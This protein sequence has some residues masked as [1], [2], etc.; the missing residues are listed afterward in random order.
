M[1]YL[2]SSIA[3]WLKSDPHEQAKRM[4]RLR[5]FGKRLRRDDDRLF[6]QHTRQ[7]DPC[8]RDYDRQ[9]II[10][11]SLVGLDTNEPT[12]IENRLLMEETLARLVPESI[13]RIS[14]ESPVLWAKRLAVVSLVLMISVIGFYTTLS[15]NSD[16][17]RYHGSIGEDL[18]TRGDSLEQPIMGIGV[19][20]VDDRGNEYEIVASR[21][22]CFQHALKFYVTSRDSDYR[23]YFIFG[24]QEERVLWYFPGKHEVS[25]YSLPQGQTV[26]HLVPYEIIIRKQHEVGKLTVIGLISADAL[27]FEQVNE[28]LSRLSF[29]EFVSDSSAVTRH[30]AGLATVTTTQFEI[31]D[32]EENGYE[33]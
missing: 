27:E 18:K 10:L 23:Y 22:V 26:A 12:G 6:L 9:T 5:F 29:S 19:S 8:R 4:V 20:G 24:L 13:P 17:D 3:N 11:R 21:G 7:C 33:N 32:C 2:F 1:G 15:K 31:I 16:R 25:S 14:L 30:F 28:I